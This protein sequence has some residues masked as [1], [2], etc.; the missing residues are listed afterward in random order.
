MRQSNLF[1]KTRRESPSDEVSLNAELLIRAG[2][3]N[4]VMAGVYEFLPLG[5]RSVEKIISVI[6]DEMNEI[7][8]QE[9]L[10]SS[11]QDK[12]VWDRTDRWSDEEVDVW[13]KGKLKS[14][15]DVGFG[16]THE[17]AITVMMKNHI[18]S[19]K[20]LPKYVYQFQTKFR[21]E[22]RAKSG[23]MRTKEF[24]MKDLY[25]FSKNEE[26]H[27]EFYEKIANSYMNVFKRVGIGDITYRTSA[28]GGSFSKFSDE[29]QTV[30]DS[31]EDIIYV[32]KDKNMAINEEV[33]NDEVLDDLGMDKNSFEKQKASEVGNIFTLGEKFAEPL[34]L[35]Y[36]NEMG[37]EVPVFMGSYGIGPARLLGVVSEIYSSE[38]ELILPEE[39]SPFRYHLISLSEKGED[40][41]KDLTDRGIDVLFDDREISA[42][43]KFKDADLIGIPNRLVVS[44]R[45]I[46][47]GGIEHTNRLTKE[48]GIVDVNG[49]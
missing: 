28:S 15:G 2:Y 25:S 32:N 16:W 8:G 18:S 7:G 14:G 6:R 20:D 44:E 19:H 42:G 48:E 5:L 26:E 10:L 46:E 23:I 4:K 11:L 12:D 22:K 36:K 35:K 17:E 33:F 38:S 47:N 39:V 31:G 30:C 34:G 29:F 37:D 9:V 13:F 41:Y 1:T 24:I 49:L 45:S 21:N 3:I 40:V 27:K 43:E